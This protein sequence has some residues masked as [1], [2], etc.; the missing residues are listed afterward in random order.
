MLLQRNASVPLERNEKCENERSVGLKAFVESE[1]LRRRSGRHRSTD[2]RVSKS[3]SLDVSLE[4][5][6]IPKIGRSNTPEIVLQVSVA[7]WRSRSLLV[8]LVPSSLEFGMSDVVISSHVGG[9]FDRGVV[10]RFEDLEIELSSLGRVERHSERH[11]GVRESLHSDTDRSVSHVGVFG[12][13]DGVVVDV[14]NSVQVE[15]DDLQSRRQQ[16]RESGEETRTNLDDIVKFLEIVD[17][18]GDESRQSDRSEIADG[19]IARQSVQ[20]VVHRRSEAH[21]SSGAE[22][23]MISVH[24]F[25]DLIVP[26]FFWF[27][28]PVASTTSQRQGREFGGKDERLAASL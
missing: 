25:D 12:F 16:Q 1:D 3:E 15:R 17:S 10:D 24:K 28:F 21:H 27:D 19:T 7:R 14:D 13:L 22:Y 20:H 23:S 4:R 5:S 6:P 2:E 9:R 18:G 8:R 11:E 26:K